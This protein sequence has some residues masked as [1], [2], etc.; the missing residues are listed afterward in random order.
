MDKVTIN[1]HELRKPVESINL[2]NRYVNRQSDNR[3]Y[4]INKE[5]LRQIESM[6]DGWLRNIQQCQYTEINLKLDMNLRGNQTINNKSNRK[7][8]HTE[9]K[10]KLNNN[11]RESQT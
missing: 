4:T 1:I 10:V 3:T 9:E 5:K 7:V 11:S 6:N 8:T 2:Q